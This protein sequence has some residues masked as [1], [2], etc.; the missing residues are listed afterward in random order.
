[1]SSLEEVIA[2]AV[3][4]AVQKYM[5]VFLQIVSEKYQ[6]DHEELKK[7]LSENDGPVE[8]S[9][10]YQKMNIKQLRTLCREKNIK[11]ISQKRKNELIEI[12]QGLDAND[13]ESMNVLADDHASSI[14]SDENILDTSELHDSS[15]DSTPL[16]VPI[17]EERP[18]VEEQPV[19][20][21]EAPVV[22]ERSEV[23]EQPVLVQEAPVVEE[24]AEVEEQPLLVP[25]LVQEA[26]V[27]EERPEPIQVKLIDYSKM[28]MDQLKKLCREKKIKTSGKRK[29]HLIECLSQPT[30][31]GKLRSNSQVDLISEAETLRSSMEGLSESMENRNMYNLSFEDLRNVCKI[32]GIDIRNKKKKDLITCLETFDNHEQNFDSALVADEDIF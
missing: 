15:M 19:L 8:V 13:Q 2:K 14:S 20:V 31:D 25:P 29:E 28:N 1:M 24:R 7:L 6:I 3:Q 32:R 21:Q 11:N 30:E 16:G 9:N 27:V 17:M 26:P 10:Q 23:E 18:E 12:L 22:E 4:G 5:D